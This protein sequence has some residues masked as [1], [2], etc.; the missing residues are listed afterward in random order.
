M[1][2]QKQNLSI[3]FSK[4]IDTL[5]DSFLVEADRF[6][7]IENGIFLK[8]GALKKRSGFNQIGMNLIGTDIPITGMQKLAIFNDSLVALS[9]GTLYS[10]AQERDKWTEKGNFST[11]DINTFPVVRNSESQ[12]NFDYV[13]VR[14]IDINVWQQG[15][16]I[17]YSVQDAL[18]NSN[19]VKDTILHNSVTTGYNGSLPQIGVIGDIVLMFYWVAETNDKIY[20]KIIGT[21]SPGVVTTVT[22]PVA[23]VVA[24]NR[25]KPYKVL[26]R[27]SGV[28]LVHQDSAAQAIITKFVDRY[29]AANSP[30]FPV[31]T[32]TQAGN[33]T[34]TSMAITTNDN[35]LF[36]YYSIDH[37][38]STVS[39]SGSTVTLTSTGEIS[40]FE[41]GQTLTFADASGNSSVST[42]ISG[43]NY[44]N[45]TFTVSSPT[46]VVTGDYVKIVGGACTLDVYRWDLPVYS[47]TTKYKSLRVTGGVSGLVSLYYEN[48]LSLKIAG[49]PTGV[50][51]PLNDVNIKFINVVMTNPY[52]TNLSTFTIAP[53]LAL[54]VPS[55]SIASDLFLVDDVLYLVASYQGQTADIDNL[56]PTRFILDWSGVVAAKVLPSISGNH[57]TQLTHVTVVGSKA[58]FPA[59]VRTR[60]VSQ[61]GLLLATTGISKVEADFGNTNFFVSQLGE[62]LHITGGFLYD[63]DGQSVV[64]HGFHLFPEK[65]VITESTGGTSSG[66]Y[67][68]CAVYEWVDTRGQLHQS[69]PSASASTTTMVSK[70]V[71]VSVGTYLPLTAKENVRIVLYRTLDAGTTFYRLADADNTTAW[72]Y[73]DTITDVALQSNMILY[74]TGGVIENSAPPSCTIIQ[75]HNNRL[76]LSGLEDVNTIWYSKEYVEN[77]PVNFSDLLYFKVNPSGGAVTALASLDDK[78]IIFKSDSIYALAGQG[79]TDLGTQNDFL[80][81][82]FITGN[83]GCIVQESLVVI[84]EGLMFK[85]DKG[86]WIL[87]RALGLEYIGAPVED[88][89]SLTITA[90]LSIPD[91]NQV[92]F[93]T[94]DGS[95]LVYQSLLKQWTTFTNYRALHAISYANEF[96]HIDTESLIQKESGAAS[97]NAM[98]VPLKIETSWLKIQVQ[99]RFRLYTM[100]LLGKFTGDPLLRISKYSDYDEATP[101]FRLF[102]TNTQLDLTPWGEEEVYWGTA[103][104]YGSE[105]N[106]V[107]QFN[108]TW[109]KQKLSSVKFIFEDLASTVMESSYEFSNLTLQIGL[110]QGIMDKGKQGV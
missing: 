49:S 27:F 79:P 4:G 1:P 62:N 77:E 106:R 45:G 109:D 94:L 40:H 71:S 110:A 65:P 2:I 88:F 26:S 55:I 108:C 44:S 102:T 61:D 67:E 63:Y 8:N 5:N 89:N 23:N 72:T 90:G 32:A 51:D 101:E 64:E 98:F 103:T 69:T 100:S 11:A 91:K 28:L 47:E 81:P 104:T 74:T 30:L 78:L 92:I 84:P 7:S 3:P 12:S 42:T 75:R 20:V 13:R 14:D 18:S 87:T 17:Y 36:L 24:G 22:A 85:S 60:L 66:N 56:Q 34:S 57:V 29:G 80:Q 37:N 15:N 96:Y 21:G 59:G 105:R 10:Y 50:I 46:G 53:T 58:Y 107:F 70:A 68:Y 25:L 82:Q 33:Y 83:I 38:L 48:D 95:A 19:I 31:E 35:T 93:T 86:I 99:E 97:D 39:I 6:L 54:T 9:N 52:I 41:N 73:A 76:F 16:D 43:V